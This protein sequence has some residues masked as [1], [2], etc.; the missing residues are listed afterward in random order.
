MWDG[1]CSPNRENALADLH[2]RQAE[3][4]AQVKILLAVEDGVDR[5]QQR[6]GGSTIKRLAVDLDGWVEQIDK[7]IATWA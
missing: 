6:D 7:A 3:E 5:F 1:R 2:A 4:A